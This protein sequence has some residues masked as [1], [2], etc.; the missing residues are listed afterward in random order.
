RGK[1]FSPR[2]DEQCSYRCCQHQ[3]YPDALHPMV[4]GD[5]VFT[6]FHEVQTCQE[7]IAT[8]RMSGMARALGSSFDCPGGIGAVR[9]LEG[10]AVDGG[11]IDEPQS[12]CHGGYQH[13]FDDLRT[14]WYPR[15]RFPCEK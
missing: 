5:I 3:Q 11:V 10:I 9:E 7:W 6:R 14:G 15:M 4:L 13:K 1:S 2:P 8:A 12:R